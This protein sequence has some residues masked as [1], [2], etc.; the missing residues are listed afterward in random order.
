MSKT[1]PLPDPQQPLVAD[2]WRDYELLESGSGMKMERWGDVVLVRPDPQA[3][4]RPRSKWSKW[5]GYYHRSESGGGNW[6]F[7]RQLPKSWVI[8]YGELSLKISPTDFKHTGLFP[9]QAVNWDWYS[10]KI[11]KARAAGEEV[12]VLNLFGYTGAATIACAA[13]GASVCHVDASKGMVQWC[14]ENAA[15]SGLTDRP[16]RYIVDDCMKFV[17][18]EARRGKKYDAII[19]DPPAYGRGAGGEMWKLDTHLNLLLDDCR[20]LLS[21]RPLFFLINSYASRLAPLGLSSLLPDHIP[22]AGGKFSV[23]ELGLR[24]SGDGKILPCGIY[25]RWERRD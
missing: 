9:E 1:L 8:R 6:D 3:I 17:A 12:S 13:A 5:D 19:M 16:I 15:L 14:R 21:E 18:R 10:E 24:G 25:G 7:R 11:R 22:S 2:R 23:G 4:W 20:Q